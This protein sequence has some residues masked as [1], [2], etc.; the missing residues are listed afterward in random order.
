MGKPILRR[1]YLLL[2]LLVAIMVAPAER[3]NECPF[4]KPVECERL[5]PQDSSA[6]QTWVTMVRDSAP[7]GYKCNSKTPPKTLNLDPLSY[8][9]VCKSFQYDFDGDTLR[10]STKPK[11]ASKRIPRFAAEDINTGIWQ[12][13]MEAGHCISEREKKNLFSSILVARSS[14]YLS[15]S[16]RSY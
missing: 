14:W 12:V 4:K 1:I 15:R 2:N 3:E 7:V 10:I 13:N 8:N 6:P 11:K 5:D 16:K 9:D